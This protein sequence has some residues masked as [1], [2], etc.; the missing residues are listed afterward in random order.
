MQ[1][2]GSISMSPTGKI[3]LGVLIFCLWGLNAEALK[4]PVTVNVDVPAGEFKAV[5]LRNLPRGSFVA[6]E[7][8]TDGEIER[9]N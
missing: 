2:S 9:M 3:I 4:G 6:V 5:R 7:V 1:D 8:K